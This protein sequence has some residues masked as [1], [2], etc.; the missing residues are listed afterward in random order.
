MSQ[1]LEREEAD[2]IECFAADALACE[3]SGSRKVNVRDLALI[4]GAT[5]KTV[6]QQNVRF[7]SVQRTQDFEKT[8]QCYRAQTDTSCTDC[9]CS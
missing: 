3:D 4:D 7:S 2:D 1:S 6:L 8:G 9:K 5:T